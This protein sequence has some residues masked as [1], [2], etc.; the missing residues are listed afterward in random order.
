MRQKRRARARE[1]QS[2]I[3]SLI[4][5]SNQQSCATSFVLEGLVASPRLAYLAR[6][7]A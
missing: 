3:D 2:E 4:G 6:R 7:P 1:L 5:S